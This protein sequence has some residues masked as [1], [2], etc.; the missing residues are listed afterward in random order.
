MRHTHARAVRDEGL[1]L[2]G[3][4]AMGSVL[5]LDKVKADVRRE[6]HAQMKAS[7]EVQKAIQIAKARDTLQWGCGLYSVVVL[8]TCAATLKNRRFPGVVCPPPPGIRTCGRARPDAN[9]PQWCPWSSGR[10]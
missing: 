3:S 6:V 4:C 7:M 10:T 9:S 5:S 1:A 2:E 8:G